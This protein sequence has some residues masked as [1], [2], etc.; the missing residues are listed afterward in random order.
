MKSREIVEISE[1][2]N[3]DR[4][5]EAY[6]H[7]CK[8]TYTFNLFA[9]YSFNMNKTEDTVQV[10]KKIRHSYLPYDKQTKPHFEVFDVSL[11]VAEHF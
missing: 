7:K 1:K 10:C 8:L 3:V 9:T 5:T 4:Q 6:A 2:R 11:R